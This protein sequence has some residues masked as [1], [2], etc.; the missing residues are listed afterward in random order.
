MAIITNTINNNNNNAATT[1]RQLSA[2]QS[3]GVAGFFNVSNVLDEE[4]LEEIADVLNN[5]QHDLTWIEG[6]T[7]KGK[8]QF[9]C[10]D[11]NLTIGW[12]QPGSTGGVPGALSFSAKTKLAKGDLKARFQK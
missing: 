2:M 1:V 12:Y 6:Q 8:Q 4:T 7:A 11:G 3:S 5:Y 9:T 10:K